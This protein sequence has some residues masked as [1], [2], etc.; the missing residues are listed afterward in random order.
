MT[1]P[2][3]HPLGYRRLRVSCDVIRDDQPSIVLD[4]PETVAAFCEPLLRSPQEIVLWIGV[5][6]R[7]AVQAV[8]ELFRGTA[9]RCQVHP[10]DVFAA[11]LAASPT[12]SGV[13]LVH[14]HPSGNCEPSDDDV[15]FFD[16][17]S[18][19]GELL[20]IPVLDCFVV[21]R[22]G[23]W[24]RHAGAVTRPESY[25]RRLVEAPAASS[26]AAL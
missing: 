26:H 10:R 2:F 25:R 7:K 9:D 5:D 6:C 13:I 14:N 17:V 1:P 19:A 8:D 16:R 12:V 18:E 23:W 20:C 3:P 11:A 15:A 22:E 24:S 4:R 21:A